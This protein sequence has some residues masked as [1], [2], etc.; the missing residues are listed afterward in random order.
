MRLE[1]EYLGA[2]PKDGEHYLLKGM[3]EF[4]YDK[5]GIMFQRYIVKQQ[6]SISWHLIISAR[7]GF[8]HAGRLSVFRPI[9]LIKWKNQDKEAESGF[10]LDKKETVAFIDWFNKS[11]K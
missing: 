2:T 6:L 10:I 11:K 7:T 4:W 1:A 9:L 8:L 3:G 5:L